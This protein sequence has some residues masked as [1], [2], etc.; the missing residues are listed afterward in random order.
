MA[1]YFLSSIIL[2]L[3]RPSNTFVFEILNWK[4]IHV[5]FVERPQAHKGRRPSRE[6]VRQHSNQMG[7]ENDGIEDI[8]SSRNP[9]T[10]RLQELGMVKSFHGEINEAKLQNPQ[11]SESMVTKS[12]PLSQ[13][14][15]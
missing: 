8:F 15:K 12:V 13:M 10:R 6:Q 11:M 2:T 3:N 7:P 14:I 5:R 9:S 1:L 4:T